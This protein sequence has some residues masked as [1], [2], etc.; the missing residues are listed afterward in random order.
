MLLLVAFERLNEFYMSYVGLNTLDLL[1][2]RISI[3]LIC[4]SRSQSHIRARSFD[5]LLYY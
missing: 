5:M 1:S 4:W 2:L 3:A